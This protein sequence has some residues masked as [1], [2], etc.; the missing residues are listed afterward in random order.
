[1]SAF[2]WGDDEEEFIPVGLSVTIG[3]TKVAPST[4]TES[5]AES[6]AETKT[7]SG[8][9]Y[10]YAE[11][12]VCQCCAAETVSKTGAQ[13]FA[14]LLF[15]LD[16]TSF[17]CKYLAPIPKPRFASCTTCRGMVTEENLRYF[18]HKLAARIMVSYDAIRANPNY[19]EAPYLD[20]WMHAHV[21]R[22]NALG[23]AMGQAILDYQNTGLSDTEDSTADS[24]W[25]AEAEMRRPLPTLEYV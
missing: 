1:M 17:P 5:N 24:F 6:N 15:Q 19:P 16:T 13:R 12:V 10:M 9:T 4:K 21:N 11:A 2:D 18:Y 23:A 7:E 20:A 25:A 3:A 8:P 22:A 14:K